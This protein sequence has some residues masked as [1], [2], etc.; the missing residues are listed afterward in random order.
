[1]LGE[2][3]CER[4]NEDTEKVDLL[5]PMER[6]GVQFKIPLESAGVAINKLRDEFYDMMLYATQFATLDYRA[7]WWRLFHSPSSSSWPN[8]LTLSQLLFS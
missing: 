1:M 7:V 2:E 6:L 4:D 8:V 5:E 3:D